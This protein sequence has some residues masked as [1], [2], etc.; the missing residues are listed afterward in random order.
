[1]ASGS[2]IARLERRQI[3]AASLARTLGLN[4]QLALMQCQCKAPNDLVQGRPNC[5]SGGDLVAEFGLRGGALRVN[6]PAATEGQPDWVSGLVRQHHTKRE[7]PLSG[8]RNRP[9]GVQHSVA[10]DLL[11]CFG[12]ISRGCRAAS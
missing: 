11:E 6:S 12:W 2:T 9:L 3:P 4:I 10:P 5:V 8:G 1:M 7:S